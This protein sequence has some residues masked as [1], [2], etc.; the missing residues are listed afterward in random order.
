[1]T[2]S[3]IRLNYVNLGMRNKMMITGRVENEII[4]ISIIGDIDMFNSQLAKKELWD[5]VQNKK[6]VGLRIDMRDCS[7]L[8][9]SGVGVLF[10]FIKMLKKSNVHVWVTEVTESVLSIIKLA[11]LD[12]YF[13]GENYE[14]AK[15]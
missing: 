8:D 1:M 3:S 12:R 9:S 4:F 2:L 5:T 13:L 14:S 11:G 10:S 15:K 7:Y 6:I